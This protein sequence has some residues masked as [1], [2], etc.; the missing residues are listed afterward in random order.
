MER[1]LPPERIGQAVA[2]SQPEQRANITPAV[3]P[4]LASRLAVFRHIVQRVNEQEGYIDQNEP[5]VFG[6]YKDGVLKTKFFDMDGR[7]LYTWNNVADRMYEQELAN[8]PE[9]KEVADAVL[10]E[11]RASKNPTWTAEQVCDL[12]NRE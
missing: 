9:T 4:K 2:G 5:H 6:E 1:P 3:S 12:F 10:R 11:A 8:R 7:F